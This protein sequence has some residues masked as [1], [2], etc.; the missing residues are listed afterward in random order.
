[1]ETEGQKEMYKRVRAHVDRIGPHIGGPTCDYTDGVHFPDGVTNVC[2]VRRFAENGR[3]YGYDTIYVL[4]LKHNGELGC[5]E[6]TNTKPTKGYVS[7][8]TIKISGADVELC[9]SDES[10]W[11]V[12]LKSLPDLVKI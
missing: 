7:I 6:V 3:D 12:P 10:V 8:V 4:W 5:R 9:L 11:K 1:M 2:A